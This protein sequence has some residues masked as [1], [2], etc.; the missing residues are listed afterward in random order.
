MITAVAN[1]LE[2]PN[3]RAR[4]R[5]ILSRLGSIFFILTRE[6]PL[7]ARVHALG[8]YTQGLVT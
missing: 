1:L 5:T 8:L 7:L 2:A 4:A 3:A 6:S